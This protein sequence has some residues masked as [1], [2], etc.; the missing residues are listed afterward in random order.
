[1]KKFYTIESDFMAQDYKIRL[2]RLPDSI[3]KRAFLLDEW[4]YIDDSRVFLQYEK[5]G[6]SLPDVYTYNVPLVSSKFKEVLDDAGITNCFFKPV[7]LFENK[8]DIAEY[9]LMLVEP[10]DCVIWDKSQHTE[11]CG[12]RKITGGFEI[13]QNKVGNFRIFK[14]KDVLNRFWIIDEHL[15]VRLEEA[16]INAARILEIGEYWGL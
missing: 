16:G 13:D 10:L 1:M 5:V 9:Y 2:G 7:C 15:K 4:Q 6:S 8:E 12:L 14:I 11:D 3:N